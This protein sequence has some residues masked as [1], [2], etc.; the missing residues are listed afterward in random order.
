MRTKSDIALPEMKK[1]PSNKKSD[2]TV[3]IC[4]YVLQSEDLAHVCILLHV[5]SI[6]YHMSCGLLGQSASFSS[7]KKI[8]TD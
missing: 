6:C 7:H 1:I 8:P 5:H 2:S 3:R 4:L